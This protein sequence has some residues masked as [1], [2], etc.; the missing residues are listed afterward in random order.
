MTKK[1]D[2]AQNPVM[3]GLTTTGEIAKG[4]LGAVAITAVPM[5]LLGL[6]AGLIVLMVKAPMRRIVEV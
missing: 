2:T 1:N 3:D 5:L 6:C 4:M